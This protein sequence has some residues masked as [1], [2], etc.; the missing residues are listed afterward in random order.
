MRRWWIGCWL[1]CGILAVPVFAGI[2]LRLPPNVLIEGMAVGASTRFYEPAAL[3]ET[4][5]AIRRSGAAVVELHTGQTLSTNLTGSV[6]GEAMSEEET[7]SLRRQATGAGMRLVA[8]R[9]RFG[10][11]SSAITRLF[12]WADRLGIQVLV[13]DPPAEQ[14]DHVERMVRQYNV[15]VGLPTGL[16]SAAGRERAGGRSGWTDPKTVLAALRGRDLRIGV[17][18]NVLNLVRAGVDPFEALEELRLRLIGVQVVDLSELSPKA[19]PVPFGT[20]AFDFRRMLASLHAHRFDGYVVFD[21][22]PDAPEFKGDL[23]AGV[24]MFRKEMESIRRTSA[25]RQAALG[26]TVPE[27]M[28][29]EVLLQGDIPEPVHVARCPD[30]SIWFASRRGAV[31]A[32][33]PGARTNGLVARFPV[34]TSGQRGLYG[35]EFDPGFLTNGSVYVYRAP[36]LSAG[37]SNR[38]SRFTA[39]GGPGA[40]RVGLETERVLLDIP[41]SRHGLQQGGGLLWHPKEG[42]LYVGTGDNIPPNE[43]PRVY[44]DPKS[45]PQDLG[46]LRG[47][48]LRIAPDGSVPAGNPWAATAGARHEVF[49]I[50]LRNPVTLAWDALGESVLAGD[51]GYDRMRDQE[52][53]NRVEAGRNYG[54]PRCDGRHRDTLSGAACPLPD[55]VGPWFSYSHDSAAAVMVGVTV[56]RPLTGWPERFGAGLFY[57]DFSRR[58]VRFAQIDPALNA[59]TNTVPFASGLAGGVMSMTLTSEGELYLVEYGG[60][61]SGSPED[62]LSR[63]VPVTK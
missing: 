18:V 17:V 13:G 21:P 3:G 55:A 63:I 37:N 44:D 12:E 43:T 33:S 48:I 60:N 62:R 41:S 4:L 11:N 38:V 53:V 50:G 24:A 39:T 30:G 28:R 29:Y 6:V 47:K 31:W 19:R 20:G 10:N 59:V 5:E 57:S 1:F 45:A 7:L 54:W 34:S 40:W 16:P 35:F 36:I 22:P 9:V 27:G 8:A 2:S 51:V 58:V 46:D 25:L 14:Y 56:K 61:L 52:E 23:N 26:A 42:N 49:A 15:A 32:W